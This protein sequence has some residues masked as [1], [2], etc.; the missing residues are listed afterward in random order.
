MMKHGKTKNTQVSVIVLNWNQPEFT[1]DCVRSVLEQTFK[2]FEILLIDNASSDDSVERLREQ[3]LQHEKITIIENKENL[4]YA[5]GN[6]EGVKQSRGEYVTILNN[7]TKVEKDWLEELVRVLGSDEKTAA[8][9]S[10]EIREGVKRINPGTNSSQSL[11]GYSVRSENKKSL[12]SPGIID[13]FGINGCSFIY[14]KEL[15]NPPFDP[16]YFIYAEDA[17]LGW[18][19]KLKGYSTKISTKSIVHHFHNLTKKTNGINTRFVFL[20]ERNRIMNALIFYESGTLIKILP[21]LMVNIILLN[22]FEPRKALP[23]LRA[24]LWILSHLFHIN[25]KRKR[26]QAQRVIPDKE[27]VKNMTCKL[28]KESKVKYPFRLFLQMVNKTF[29]LYCFMFNIRTEE[30]Q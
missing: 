21:M 14:R 13:T 1:I 11:L 15:A 12:E 16:E 19:L 18:L 24:Y 10:T 6:N 3:F 28:L 4:G 23:R 17:Y 5:G 22:I 7:D 20:G 2:D 27:V 25:D 29:H 8:V 26:I 9:S 30:F